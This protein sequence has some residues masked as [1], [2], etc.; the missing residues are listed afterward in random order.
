MFVVVYTRTEMRTV[1]TA[2]SPFAARFVTNVIVELLNYPLEYSFEYCEVMH[3]LEE[4]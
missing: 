1:K 2:D 3:V 4:E